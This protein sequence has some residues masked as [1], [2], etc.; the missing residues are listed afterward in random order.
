MV[1]SVE[2]RRVAL[3]AGQEEL[4]E[5]ADRVLGELDLIPLDRSIV[6]TAS[7]LNPPAVRALDAIHVASAL[8]LGDELESFVS[9]DLRQLDAAHGAGLAVASPG[10]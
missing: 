6:L 10:A 7:K 1:A 3:R 5:K 8:A 9:Y 2:V 4:I